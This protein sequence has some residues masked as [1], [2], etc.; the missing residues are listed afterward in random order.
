MAYERKQYGS[1]SSITPR[2]SKWAT[3]QY[4]K[5]MAR[6]PMMNRWTA[7]SFMCV[8]IFAIA[9]MATPQ[10]GGAP[11]T[12]GDA[13]D[14]GQPAPIVEQKLTREEVHRGSLI[15]V[16]EE[17]KYVFPPQPQLISLKGDG[18]T[19]QD[20]QLHPQAA[21]ALKQMLS[22]CERANGGEIVRIAGA[23]RDKQTQEQPFEQYAAQ[24]EPGERASCRGAKP[25]CSEHHTGYAVDLGAYGGTGGLEGTRAGDWLT[26]NCAQYGFIL[27]GAAHKGETTEHSEEPW[28]FRYVGIPHA[29]LMRKMDLSLAEYIDWLRDYP[30]DKGHLHCID[31][32]AEYEIYFVEAQGRRTSVPV[33]EG[34]DYT[35]SGNNVDG[36]IVTIV[37]K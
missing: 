37:L 15:L 33:R 18:G 26:E 12:D 19:G 11:A 3:F 13:V 17:N 21:G 9:I 23:F 35:V 29:A 1:E 24:A 2:C 6:R 34:Y 36:F 5:R 8:L 32:E 20:W 28:H 27:P 22:D 14:S 30:G 25:G 7:L 10:A 31:G 4:G 16:N